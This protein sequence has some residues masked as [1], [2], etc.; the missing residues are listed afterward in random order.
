MIESRLEPMREK[1]GRSGDRTHA[2]V[3]KPLTQRLVSRVSRL[4]GQRNPGPGSRDT[5]DATPGVKGFAAP[6]VAIPF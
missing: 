1:S 5:L 2:G 6:G 4:P 3:A